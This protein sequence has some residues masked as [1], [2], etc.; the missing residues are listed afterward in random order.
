MKKIISFTNR[1]HPYILTG[2]GCENGICI[3]KI[4][5]GMTVVFSQLGI[6]RTAKKEFS[7]SLKERKEQGIDPFKRKLQICNKLKKINIQR[8]RRH[9]KFCFSI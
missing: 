3:R 4:D 1:Q 7:K 2:D 6:Q 5:K 9:N 8:N